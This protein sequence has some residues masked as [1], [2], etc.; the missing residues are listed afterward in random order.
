MLYNVTD[1]QAYVYRTLSSHGEL[2][3]EQLSLMRTLVGRGG[4]AEEDLL[5]D[6]EIL[7][8]EEDFQACNQKLEGEPLYAKQLVGY[9]FMTPCVSCMIFIH[10]R[11]V[12]ILNSRFFISYNIWLLYNR[13]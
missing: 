9:H 11:Y 1:F 10:N 6:F 5:I 7:T 4:N 8:T 12:M 3:R 2:L 13:V